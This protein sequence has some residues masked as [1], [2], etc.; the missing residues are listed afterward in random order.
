MPYIVTD[1]IKRRAEKL[2]VT[3]KSSTD[4]K[5]KLDVYMNDKLIARIGQAHAFDYH[6]WRAVDAKHADERRKAYYNRHTYS[7]KQINGIYT[8]DYLAKKLLW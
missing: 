4:P 7:V 5:K 2:G 6:L 3:V 1:E 8:A